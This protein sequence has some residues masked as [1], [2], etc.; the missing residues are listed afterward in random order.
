MTDYTQAIEDVRSGMTYREAA[1]LH[2]M[3]SSV[4]HKHCRRAGIGARQTGRRAGD[5]E[6]KTRQAAL[7][8]IR[9]FTYR[10]ACERTGASLGAVHRAVQRMGGRP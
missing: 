3:P 10:E 5:V 6:Q 2:G 7:L 9:G 4:L 1:K 8:A